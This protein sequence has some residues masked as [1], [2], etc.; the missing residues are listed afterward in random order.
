MLKQVDLQIRAAKTQYDINGSQENYI[1]LLE[2]Q[3]EKTAVLAQIEGFRSEQMTN[4]SGLA[5]EQLELELSITDAVAERTIAELNAAA[6]LIKSDEERLLK[7]LENLEIEKQIEQQRLE[8]KRDSYNADTQAYTDSQIELENFISESNIRK[9]ALDDELTQ[10]RVENNKVI[11]ATEQ[12]KIDGVKNS[13]TTIANLASLFAGESEEQQKK[14]FKVQKA[15][16]IA[17]ALIDTYASA[18]AA[19]KSLS[20][21]PVVGVGLGIAAAAAAVT[22]GLL[23]VK[24]IQAQ[25]FQGAGGGASASPSYSASTG[26]TSQ[27][28]DFNVVGQSGFNQ[29][30]TAL[31][32]NN[33]TPIQAYVVS[34]DVTTAQQLDNNIIQTATF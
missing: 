12:Q 17:S 7:Q 1:A 8:L 29:V 24:Q 10:V 11:E 22:G 28:P 23:N 32:Q 33:D 13:L 18:T 16:S 3:T 21:I 25:E 31:G 2:A 14:A 34:G 9:A 19:F 26:S 20:G 27:A 4:A 5:K 6:E 15:V 30:A